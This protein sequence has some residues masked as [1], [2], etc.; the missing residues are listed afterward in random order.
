MERRTIGLDGTNTECDTDAV[1]P[2]TTPV[3]RTKPLGVFIADDSAVIRE[4]LR[5][6]LSEI[7]DVTVVGDAADVA[8][9]EKGIQSTKPDVAIVDIRMP[10]GSGIDVVR[11]LKRGRPG[12]PSFIMFTSYGLP[13]YRQASAEAGADFF[14]EKSTETQKLADAIRMLASRE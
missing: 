7:T 6:M 5:E 4:R 12:G 13:Q 1:V 8:T 14:F 11:K 2:A 9:A 10:G 3:S